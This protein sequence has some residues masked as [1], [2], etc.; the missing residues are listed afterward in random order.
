MHQ[1]LSNRES[2]AALAHG[3]ELSRLW[4]QLLTSCCFCIKSCDWAYLRSLV[5]SLDWRV[6]FSVCIK[7]QVSF[8]S[9]S[10]LSWSKSRPD[11]VL[12]GSTLGLRGDMSQMRRQS[13]SKVAREVCTCLADNF[14]ET[15]SVAALLACSKQRSLS[16]SACVRH[17]AQPG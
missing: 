6:S 15:S 13:E 8:T 10:S 9:Q 2:I 4:W 5:R 7:A 1:L 16:I 14:E 3:S 12:F 17:T 11:Q